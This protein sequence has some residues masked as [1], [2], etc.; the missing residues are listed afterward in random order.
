MPSPRQNFGMACVHGRLF[1]FGG[2]NRSTVLNELYEYE[3]SL[4]E[5]NIINI[6]DSGPTPR[7]GHGFASAQGNLYVFGGR[8]QN[9]DSNKCICLK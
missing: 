4:R 2:D 6:S 8:D 3:I 5:W 1:V 7:T 9:G